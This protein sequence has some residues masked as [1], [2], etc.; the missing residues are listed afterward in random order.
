M[1]ALILFML[2]PLLSEYLLGNIPLDSV[3]SLA[4]YPALALLYGGGALLIREIAVRRGRGWP[5]TV[6]LAV[7]YG[8]VEEGLIT[9]SLFNPTYVGLDLAG[10]RVSWLVFALTIHSVWSIVIPIAVTHALFPTRRRTPWLGRGGLALTTVLYLAGAVVL[11]AGTYLE[12]RFLARPVELAAAAV[13]AAVVAA[14]A[15]AYRRRELALRTWSPPLLVA[16][17]LTA[18]TIFFLLYE[19][20]VSRRML[21][22][23]VHVAATLALIIVI[24]MVA[25]PRPGWAAVHSYAL[26]TGAVLTYCWAGVLVQSSQYGYRPVT[27]VVQ[28]T[29]ILGALALLILTRRRI[30]S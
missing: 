1:P 19:F 16:V 11:A 25:A 15:L 23:A 20:G 24:V 26:V 30:R 21:P 17:A 4:A 2:A 6:L 9:Q 12:E 10:Y 18:G 13:A 5:V 27:A 3:G 7:A 8:I 14:C 28:A 22:S 29:L